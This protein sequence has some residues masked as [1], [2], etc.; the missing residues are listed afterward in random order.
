V[1][2]RPERS[3]AT[4][5]GRVLGSTLPAALVAPPSSSAEKLAPPQSSRERAQ[6]KHRLI[7]LFTRARDA[8]QRGLTSLA[9]SLLERCLAIDGDDAHA[10]LALAR[11]EAASGNE[12]RAQQLFVAARA[13]RP[14]NVRLAHAHGVFEAR[15]GRPAAAREAFRTCEALEPGSCYAIHAWGQLEESLGKVAAARA[16][17][18][19]SPD[20]FTVL[21]AWAALE[22][23]Q[24]NTT[25]AR[26]LYKSA[27]ITAGL[28]VP[29]NTPARLGA[30]AAR[31]RGAVPSPAEAARLF[32]D[33]S[34]LET[35]TGR[36][37][38]ARSLLSKARAVAPQSAEVTVAAAG[39]EWS[40]G[41]PAAGRQLL[42][43][44]VDEM[45]AGVE[46]DRRAREAARARGRGGGQ[47]R[48]Q[49]GGVRGRGRGA[50]R[51]RG[52]GAVPGR[53][54]GEAPMRDQRPRQGAAPGQAQGVA[55]GLSAREA[56]LI[57]L[58]NGWAAL[59]ARCRRGGIKRALR[60]LG[61]AAAVVEAAGGAV[62][63]AAGGIIREGAG[64]VPGEMAGKAADE[65]G[66]RGDGG[67]GG[68]SGGEGTPGG[69]VRASGRGSGRGSP[70][71]VPSDVVG[72]GGARQRVPAAGLLFQSR[73]AL[74][75]RT[76]D[77]AQAR[78]AYRRAVALGCGAPAYV[79]WARLEEE[80]G[81][82][83]LAEK[84]F[85]R[86][87][88]EE[89]DHAPLHNARAAAAER[90]GDLREAR[91]V[92][93]GACT[94][95]ACAALLHGWGQLELRDGKHARAAAL[96]ERAATC[97]RGSAQDRAFACHAL[98][99]ARLRQRRLGDAQAA[100]TAGLALCPDSSQLLLGLALTHAHQRDHEAAR[101]L[102]RKAV[103]VDPRHAHAWRAWGV[104]EARLGETVAAR[105]ILAD[106][107]RSCRGYAPLWLAAARVEKESGNLASARRLLQEGV[108]DCGGGRVGG[109]AGGW[110]AGIAAG[111][112]VA[113]GVGRG[114]GA[115]VGLAALA[116][117]GPFASLADEVGASLAQE[118]DT[119]LA[120]DVDASLTADLDA[121]LSEEVDASLTADLD[122]SLAEEGDASLA[123]DGD[124]SLG[125]DGDVSF[126]GDASLG[127]D[128]DA[129][130]AAVLTVDEDFELSA[131]VEPDPRASEQMDMPLDAPLL[132]EDPP[133]SKAVAR[134]E[135][136]RAGGTGALLLSWAA[137]ELGAG[138]HALCQQI[139]SR[140]RSAGADPGPAYQL[141][142]VLLARQGLPSDARAVV[143]EG[144]RVA[145]S[146]APLHCL[147]GSMLDA[148]NNV[149]GARA[150]FAK[151]LRLHPGDGRTYH[152]WASLEARLLNWEGLAKLNQQARASFPPDRM[153]P[154][155]ESRSDMP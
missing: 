69:R 15:C 133:S 1:A 71:G 146:H 144:L 125:E 53:G 76:G 99:H 32:I 24:V 17:Y 123:R 60:L 45:Q 124:V 78:E 19:R 56:E 67:S 128:M 44:A 81:D 108:E 39:L 139:L 134:A 33:W 129:S 103:R 150:A 136:S 54:E 91:R 3:S 20:S 121:S 58:Y 93:A 114:G 26:S 14:S 98:G 73:G 152:A 147:M 118:L 34:A 115:D 62:G 117:A 122:V 12:E 130:P 8:Q 51:G 5:G 40:S 135:A 132:D 38:Q 140:A 86:G 80:Y 16:V 49:G 13:A 111:R 63:G 92:Y 37:R 79:G 55:P 74:L 21:A 35:R 145:P 88:A 151:A 57:E 116:S 82:A 95:G 131:G 127:E 137:L 87:A 85:A 94:R 96:F 11:L 113:G 6:A 100:F 66:G 36:L 141:Q 42:R 83:V 109:T 126:G 9:R 90:R 59:E 143:E 97:G 46:A 70:A 120:A 155:V 142:A 10:T 84:L 89:P 112:A 29:P 148:D 75:H 23:H 30:R 61:K 48:G 102:F 22:A 65:R 25:H 43:A 27:C 153:P 31:G 28:L 18:A 47:W 52:L 104:M 149:E 119:S 105:R 107:L 4:E 7:G 106:G 72:V 64:V 101:V 154:L 68:R 41:R 77:V 2:T 50:A 138:R 110:G